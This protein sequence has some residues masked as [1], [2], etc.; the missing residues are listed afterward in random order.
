MNLT[1]IDWLIVIA[2]LVGM[3][4]SVSITN[5]LMKSVTDF[6]AA[7]RNAGRYL[8]SVSSGVAGL[9]AITIVNHLEMGY[10]SGFALSWW[11]FSSALVILF[12]TVSGWVIY[13]FRSTR[14]LTLPQFFEMRYNRK[15]RIF[16]GIVAFLAGIINFGIFPAVGARFFIYFCGL[17]D[18]IL[19]VPI[20]PLTMA[21]LLGI[22]LYFVYTGGQIAVIIADFF[23]GVFVNI[24]FVVIILFMFFKMSWGQV[25]EA[26]EQT[27]VK[28]AEQEISLLKSDDTFLSLPQ[29]E[30]LQ[31][32][33][34]I[35][36]TYENSSRINPF[37]TSHVEDFNFWYFFIGIIGVMYGTMSW[38][39]TQAYNSSARSAHE[40]KMGSVLAG[41]R[42]L[43]QGLF[44]LFI[45]IAIYVFMNHP[46]FNSVSLVVNTSLDGIGTD[47]LKTQLRSPL[48]LAE[49]LPA[50]L[51]GAF[52]AVMLAAFVS[53][54]DTYLHSWGSIFIQ[55]VVMPFRKKPFDSETHLKVLRYAIFGVA[56]F[57]FLFSLLFQQNQK[58]AL[59][60][61]ITGAIFTSGSGAV[62]IGGLYWKRG[63]TQA[64]WAAMSVGAFIAVGGIILKQIPISWYTDPDSVTALKSFLYY[65][66]ELNGQVYWGMG[67]AASSLCYILI[68]LIGRPTFFNMDKLLH[69]GDH[70][71][72]DE[73]TIITEEPQ[74]GWKML[75]M[76]KEFTKS[77]KF[78]Y[79]INYVWSLGWT[80]VFIIGTIYN[81]Y[82]EVSNDAWM[83]FWKYYL[84]IQTAMA[85]IS[86]IWFTWGGFIDLKAMLTNLRSD[87]RDHGDDGWVSK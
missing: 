23:Q 24:I 41:F 58:I 82:N 2:V 38:Q 40:A 52:A 3:F 30:Q 9:G 29:Q 83:S 65:F 77:D 5:G 47:T 56:V 63:T 25:S 10:V 70:V 7:G 81:L 44:F 57:I 85:L 33:N 72:K 68:S 69:R 31:K 66:R 6:L 48:V 37:K 11:G 15:F 8:V 67:M 12:I 4:Y 73:M 32:I 79:I 55:D 49:I 71:I 17:P 45:P 80:I 61:A 39:G 36:K 76:G 16:T 51:M 43:P 60:F 13:R 53:T 54:H 74:R 27:P 64:A 50:G 46:D 78:I 84:I 62:I 86:I 26:L 19:G 34:E 1:F 42:G 28:L 87:Y 18:T 20:F 35:N 59:F 14:C 22:S 21:I 75:G